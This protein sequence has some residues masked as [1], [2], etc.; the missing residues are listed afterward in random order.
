MS[1]LPFDR[2]LVLDLSSVLAGPSCGQMFADHGAEVIK[3]EPPS[4]DT[5][6]PWPTVV[7]GTSTSFLS[8]NRGKL[9]LTLDLKSGAGRDILYKLIRKADVVISNFLPDVA[10]RLALD[11]ETVAA[12]NENIIY[13]SISGYGSKGPLRDKPGY[14]TLVLGFSGIM[15][16]TGEH[17][18]PPVRVGVSA[19]DLATGMLAYSGAVTALL[20]RAEGRAKGQKIEVSLLETAVTLLGF[21]GLNWLLAGEV[22]QRWGS[23]YGPIAPCGAY[24][25]SDG[26][27]MIAALTN[28]DWIALC[29]AIDAQG[30]AADERYSSGDA[31]VKNRHALTSDLN[32]VLRMNTV[33]HW[34]TRLDKHRVPNS[35]I[36]T[37]D[38]T[39]QHPQIL[40]NEMVVTAKA[41]SGKDMPLLGLPIKMSR[42]PG[43]IKSAPPTLGQHSRDILHRHLGLSSADLDSLKANNVI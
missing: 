33:D 23:S 6:R 11:Y 9:G 29:E 19:I 14:D 39:L 13:V 31:R 15:S 28:T 42:T 35:P 3:V 12:L 8:A 18:G 20:A 34:C 40:A 27:I 5:N 41:A 22:D 36:H 16:L 26:D 32:A 2:L 43:V 37:I 4:G 24:Q 1:V 30:L 25:C 38:Q 7:D 10:K 17:D 21:H